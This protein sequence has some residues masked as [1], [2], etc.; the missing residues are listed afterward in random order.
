MMIQLPADDIGKSSRRWPKCSG[1][2]MQ[3]E[4]QIMEELSVPLSL[5]FK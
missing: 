4:I 1:S 5:S 2:S 3:E